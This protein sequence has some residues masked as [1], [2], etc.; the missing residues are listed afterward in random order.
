[1]FYNN[2]AHAHCIN[3]KIYMRISFNNFNCKL[4]FVPR[5]KAPCAE[6]VFYFKHI[7]QIKLSTAPWQ[8]K[9]IFKET[10]S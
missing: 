10:N 6:N 1:M 8:K 9:I 2:T 5:V 7:V 3:F 4:F